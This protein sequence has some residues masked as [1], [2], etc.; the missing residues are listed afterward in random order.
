[1]RQR[2]IISGVLLVALAIVA[3]Q[4]LL[5]ES[6]SSSQATAREDGAVP[7]PTPATAT[8][9]ASAPDAKA[10]ET[11]ATPDASG[12]AG[13]YRPHP[14]SK[15]TEWK[16]G[17]DFPDKGYG[18]DTS[19]LKIVSRDGTQTFTVPEPGDPE[20]EDYLEMKRHRQF[21]SMHDGK[22]GYAIPY[23]PEWRA[24]IDGK[25]N[26]PPIDHEL[27]N[28]HS[29]PQELVA[30]VLDGLHESN[31]GLLGDLDVDQEE[32]EIICWPSFPQSRPYVR[33][34]VSDA[35]TFQYAECHAGIH[36]MTQILGGR[37]LEL[38]DLKIQGTKDYGN[39][40]LH[41]GV[42]IEAIDRANDEV[43]RINNVDT[44]IERNG[45]F[46][47]YLYKDND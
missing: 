25:R 11:L 24:L 22:D 18:F 47:V 33:V 4:W 1:M 21:Q 39:F 40:K 44:I 19:H 46:K 35:W 20:W 29:S 38:K 2:W 34:P 9:N 10:Q 28:A 15:R 17:P 14:G 8:L 45:M 42:V 7:E 41:E 12:A 30:A 37:D 5:T 32:F 16:E 27:M 43:V 26:A 3:Y 23:D 36:T 13:S 31:A 6:P